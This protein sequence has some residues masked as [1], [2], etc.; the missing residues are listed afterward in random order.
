MFLE[1]LAHDPATP[2]GIGFRVILW[3][4]RFLA[5]EL[6]ARVAF[7]ID[8]FLIQLRFDLGDAVVH[9]LGVE[10]VDFVGRLQVAQKHI[11]IEGRAVFRRQHVDILLGEEEMAEIEQLEI[12]LEELLRNFV[13]QR[14][15]SV[16]AFL[17]EAANGRSDIPCIRLRQER[18][19]RE[20]GGQDDNERGEK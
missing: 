6:D 9:A 16:M 19:G 1:Q 17:E 15:V 4:R 14:L 20:R 5:A 12:G 8:L 13:V 11:V 18:R 7:E 3:P 10:I 2:D